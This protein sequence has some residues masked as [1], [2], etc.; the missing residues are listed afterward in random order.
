MI[1]LDRNRLLLTASTPNYDSCAIYEFDGQTMKKMNDMNLYGRNFMFPNYSRSGNDVLMATKQENTTVYQYA[2]GRMLKVAT[3][4]YGDMEL[5]K[6][7]QYETDLGNGYKMLNFKDFAI[8]CHYAQFNGST[9]A[10]WHRAVL[11]Q[12]DHRH[13]TIATRENISNY[14]IHIAG[15]NVEVKPGMINNGVYTMLI[16]GNWESK[17]NPDEELS[18]TGKHII[19]TMKQNDDNPIYLQ[20]LLKDKYLDNHK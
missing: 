14:E 10:Y 15:L 3:I 13:L 5:T 19:E 6:D 11:K 4:D 20:F 8:G 17:I 16:Q 18:A 7:K 9:L 2:E 12:E 1:A